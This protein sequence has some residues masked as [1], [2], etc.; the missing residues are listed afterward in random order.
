MKT[1]KNLVSLLLLITACTL[2]TGCF[3]ISRSIKFFPNGG[4]TETAVI[5]FNKDFFNKIQLLASQDTKWKKR[6]DTLNNNTLLEAGFR[7][8]VMRTS[9][10]SVKDLIITDLPDGGKQITL[11]YSFDE[12]SVL[13]RIVKEASFRYTNG[14]NIIYDL[15][16][17][18]E[19]ESGLKFKNTV[20]NASRQFDDSL[21]LSIFSNTLAT[22][23][24]TQQIEFAF[25]ITASNAPTQSNDAKTLTWETN[26]Y[27]VLYNQVEMTADLQK[28]EGLDLP[29]VEKVDK[30]VGKVSQKDNPLIRVSIYNGNKEEVKIGTGIILK[31]MKGINTLVTNFQLMNVVEGGG[32]F[33]I[34][35]NSDSLAGIDEMTEKDV[36]QKQDLVFLRF[37][38]SEAVKTYKFASMESIIYGTKVKVYYY[39]NSLSPVVYSMD[40]MI[41]GN[42]KWTANTSVIEIKPS[43]P[44]SPEGGAVFNEAGEFVG[45]ITRSFDGEVGK[46][47]L[48]PAAYIRMKLP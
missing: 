5:T 43:K 39:P 21:A 36:D 37:S 42:K 31:Q 1:K 7:A 29:Y 26:M 6:A 44:L 9:G 16:K 34:K 22:N 19:D 48:V 4:G 23:K 18:T 12:P 41:S 2:F 45:M 32:F 47:Y 20:R 8:D 11:T 35:L 10:T 24:I 3:D 13:V 17:F 33:S 27:D 38:S 14:L 28:P 40:G 15:L 30:T 25:D 46:I